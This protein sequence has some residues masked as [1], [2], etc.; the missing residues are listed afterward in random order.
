MCPV[1]PIWRCNATVSDVQAH[2]VVSYIYVQSVMSIS[3]CNFY[4]CG[5]VI[6]KVLHVDALNFSQA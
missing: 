3:L 4:H 6:L 2:E 1:S 5:P